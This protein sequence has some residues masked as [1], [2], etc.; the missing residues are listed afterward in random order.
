M[1]A[2]P[3]GPPWPPQPPPPR[4]RRSRSCLTTGLI[5]L[6]VLAVLVI[7]GIV[8]VTLSVGD[9]G[10][11][12]PDGP[13]GDVRITSCRVDSATKWPHAD[14]TITN[15]S[16]KPSDYVIGVEFVVPSGARV[17]EADLVVD[18][19]APGQVAQGRAQSLTQVAGTVECKV[20]DV[21]RTAS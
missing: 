13:A 12:D 19:L 8:A 9:P 21:T 16:S 15:R 7:G 18:H 10:R 4:P 20:T 6:A 14:V 5:T 3:G 2:P 11:D 17:A 1:T